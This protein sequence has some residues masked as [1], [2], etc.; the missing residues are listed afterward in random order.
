MFEEQETICI[1]KEELLDRI[2]CTF[3]DGYRLVQ[4]GCTKTDM[5]QID[6]TFDKNYRFLNFRV[7]IPD[8]NAQMP[9]ITDIY[10]CAFTYENE[11]HDLFGITFDGLTINYKGTF[12]R[13]GIVTPF[14]I[15]LTST[16]KA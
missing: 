8:E 11:I 1:E 13:T 9:S 10:V 2:R 4:I 7:N 6:Y 3:D 16:D 5:L 12:Y 14:N 15:R